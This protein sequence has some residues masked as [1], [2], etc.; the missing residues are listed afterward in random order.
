[1]PPPPPPP[2]PEDLSLTSTPDS[3]I[4][5]NRPEPDVKAQ[6]SESQSSADSSSTDEVSTLRGSSSCPSDSTDATVTGKH[7][8]VG[9]VGSIVLVTMFKR[10]KISNLG[11]TSHNL[12][13]TKSLAHS[14]LRRLQ[15][16]TQL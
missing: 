12:V 6:I 11:S 2:P 14:S 10:S 3:S 5:I 1:M 8:I 16:P 9:V 15:L 4:Q 13:L 7:C